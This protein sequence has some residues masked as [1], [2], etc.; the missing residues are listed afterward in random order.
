MFGPTRSADVVSV[1]TQV[2]E[3]AVRGAGGQAGMTVGALR[4]AN[5]GPGARA[6]AHAGVGIGIE[7]LGEG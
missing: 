7:G 5:V 6:C 1:E 3:E 2:V 4:F